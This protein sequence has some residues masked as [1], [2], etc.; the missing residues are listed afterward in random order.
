MPFHLIYLL[1]A[2]NY[3]NWHFS[4]DNESYVLNSY[5]G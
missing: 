3:Q 5:L 1:V 2:S 4:G